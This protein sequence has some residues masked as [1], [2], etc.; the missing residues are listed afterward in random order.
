MSSCD[1]KD[2]LAVFFWHPR[3]QCLSQ[4]ITKHELKRVV[5]SIKPIP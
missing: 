4:Y 3:C 5:I 1:I 2:T